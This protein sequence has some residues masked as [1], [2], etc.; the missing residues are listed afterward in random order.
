[1]KKI[2]TAFIVSTIILSS[3]TLSLAFMPLDTLIE[4][5]KS[6][7]YS[8]SL[9]DISEGSFHAESML[10]NRFEFLS[11]G[12]NKDSF[13]RTGD[14]TIIKNVSK[15]TGLTSLKIEK[16]ENDNIADEVNLEIGWNNQG[17]TDYSYNTLM[18]FNDNIA[19]FYFD[20]STGYPDY[21]KLTFL[22]EITIKE[23]KINYS[24]SS[25]TMP[26]V[27]KSEI[28]FI[29]INT[30]NVGIKTKDYVNAAVSITNTDVN[31]LEPAAAQ[32]KIRGNST[33][34]FPKKPYRIKFDKKQGLFGKTKNKNWVLLADYTDISSLHNYTAFKLTNY[35]NNVAYIPLA[36]HVRV[37]VD[38]EYQGLYLLTEHPDEKEGRTNVPFNM[39]KEETLFDYTVELDSSA[40]TDQD[41]EAWFPMV[42]NGNAKIG[43]SDMTYKLALK[44]P[45]KSDF[46][47]YWMDEYQD[48]YDG[49]T[50]E[51]VVNAKA[52]N[53][54]N[55]FLT[56]LENE[57]TDFS[58]A[59][60]SGNADKMNEFIDQ[61]SIIDQVLI[62]QIMG[63]RD[64]Y[65]RSLKLYRRAVTGEKLKF[66]PIW[67]YDRAMFHNT[68]IQGPIDLPGTNG[69]GM[70]SN[71]W[72]GKY[73]DVIENRNAIASKWYSIGEATIIEIIDHLEL[74]SD[75]LKPELYKDSIMWYKSIGGEE[76]IDRNIR[77]FLDFLHGQIDALNRNY[78]Q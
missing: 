22:S 2:Y 4:M 5:G 1:M 19:Q 29:N 55:N 69:A 47:D 73:F 15:I 38:N 59:I 68:D 30:G 58:T 74:Y 46:I 48:L 24:C 39:N 70:S 64:H 11:T 54:W 26:E 50:L 66:G 77:Y 72:F 62:D 3:I 13:N 31:Y 51:S 41:V 34:A 78:V 63:M 42:V 17:V 28:P 43:Q 56:F 7:N 12:M 53:S 37:Y 21:F 60:E 40:D 76:S 44:S 71:R 65:Q 25:S 20:N 18:I 45:E 36:E 6:E 16:N 49:D 35:F 52:E 32:V 67:D 10:G 33:S 9:L 27:Q 8:L 23:I 14:G 57:I 75:Y 61:D